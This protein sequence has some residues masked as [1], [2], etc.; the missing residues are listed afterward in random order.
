MSIIED[1]PLAM[2]TSIDFKKLFY[3]DT[4]NVSVQFVIYN[5]KKKVILKFGCSKP[6]DFG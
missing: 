5:T 6:M 4:C 2:K 3:T 1:L